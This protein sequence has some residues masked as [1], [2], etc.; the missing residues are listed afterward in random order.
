[1][2]IRE[3]LNRNP[4]IT[5]GATAALIVIALIVIVWTT[6]SGG[7]GTPNATDPTATAPSLATPMP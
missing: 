7:G 2:G 1:M 5:T 3:T 4:A 6:F